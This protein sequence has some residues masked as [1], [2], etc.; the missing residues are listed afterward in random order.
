MSTPNQASDT[1]LA[2]ALK[3]RR[4]H[5]GCG[6]FAPEGW[7][8]CDGSWHLFLARRP[9]LKKLAVALRVLPRTHLE[10]PWPESIVRINLRHK[11]PFPDNTFDGVYSSHVIEHLHRNEAQALMKELHRTCRPGGIVRMAVPNLAKYIADYQNRIISPKSP[12][13]TPADTFMQRLQLR[14]PNAPVYPS[15]LRT[16]YHALV[17]F[18]SHKWLYDRD[19]LM[20]L[21]QEA[22]FQTSR[23]REI[24]ASDIPG[25]DAIERPER[26]GGG[27]TLIVEGVKEGACHA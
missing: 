5:L 17:D 6:D 24:L 27:G 9:W 23:E 8:N 26:I 11:L 1:L 20:A 3:H 22:G 16:L 7:L 4:L 19:S 14:P 21:F 10:H 25:I 2:L 12:S 18:N 13:E 15:R